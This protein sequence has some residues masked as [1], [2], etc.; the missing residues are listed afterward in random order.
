MSILMTLTVGIALC[1]STRRSEVSAIA[2]LAQMRLMSGAPKMAIA[3]PTPPPAATGAQPAPSAVVVTPPAAAVS[4]PAATTSSLAAKAPPV[5]ASGRAS[6]A[7]PTAPPA[8]AAAAPAA[9][10]VAARR[11][12]TAAE[13]NQA[14]QAVHQLVPFFTPTAAQVA[15][16]GN[17]ICT[18]FDQGMTFSQVKSKV[19]ALLGS[20][21]WLVPSSIAAQG[22]RTTV[23]LYCPGYASKLV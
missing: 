21:S 2:H 11:I 5:A 4:K 9:A 12:P 1:S 3:S 17:Q 20:L 19:S 13:V 23:G 15:R 7:P 18:A 8:A 22:V 6:G 14:I 10:T 16:V